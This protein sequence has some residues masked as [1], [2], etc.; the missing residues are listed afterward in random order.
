MQIIVYIHHRLIFFKN[1]NLKYTAISLRRS[2][3]S[4]LLFY[5]FSAIAFFFIISFQ[6]RM[7]KETSS[8]QSISYIA[9]SEFLLCNVLHSV[10]ICIGGRFLKGCFNC[11]SQQRISVVAKE[12]LIPY[13]LIQNNEHQKHTTF[14][15]VTWN[16][17]PNQIKKNKKQKCKT[18]VSFKNK[19][20]CSTQI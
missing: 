7:H 8:L 10:E 19:K 9:Y 18:R 5:I 2:F 1:D 11:Y 15:T 12:S 13:N 6:I 14:N 20:F 4:F 16:A 17:T 3:H